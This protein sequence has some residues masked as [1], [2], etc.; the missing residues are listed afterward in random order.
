MGFSQSVDDGNTHTHICAGR[1]FDTD[2]AVERE[3]DDA[4]S[5]VCCLRRPLE[6]RNRGGHPN[7]WFVVIDLCLLRVLLREELQLY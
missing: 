4:T 7:Q 5:G 1:E 3:N 2:D 6:N